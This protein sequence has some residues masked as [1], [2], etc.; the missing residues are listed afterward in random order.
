MNWQHRLAAFFNVHDDE[1]ELVSLSVA[2]YFFLGIPYVLVDTSAYALFLDAFGSQ[3]LP[4][5]YL[6]IAVGVSLLA[7]LYL[8]LADRVPIQR[9]LVL[10]MDA[11]IGITALL[12]LAVSVSAASWIAFI[13]PAWSFALINLGNII[14]WSIAGRLFDI[15]QGKRLFG[16]IGAGRWLAASAIGFLIAPLVSLLGIKN[17]LLVA[18]LSL[19]VSLLILRRL[20]NTEPFQRSLAPTVTPTRRRSAAQPAPSPNLLKNRYALMILGLTTVWVMAYFI[21]MNIYYN[22]AAVQFPDAAQLASFF[23]LISAVIGIGATIST[24]FLTGNIINRFGLRVSLFTTAALHLVIMFTFVV[25]GIAGG[26]PVILFGLAVASK[27]VDGTLNLTLD[28]AS[29]RILYQPLPTADRERAQAIA[30]GIIE[31]VGIGVGGLVLLF[32]TNV[33]NFGV[34]QQAILLL[35]V[36]VCWL[37]IASRLLRAYPLA[38][39]RA[40]T[41]RRLGETQVNLID[42]SSLS[43]LRTG[44]S[45][46]HPDAVIYS[47]GLLEQMGAASLP[48]ILPT[49]LDH[50]HPDVRLAAL[51]AIQR[52]KATSAL[53]AIAQRLDQEPDVMV[54]GTALQTL[55]SLGHQLPAGQITAYLHDPQ[56]PIRRGVLIGLSR[57]GSPDN[58][59]LASDYLTN[60]AASPHAADRVLVA[61]ILGDL[62]NAQSHEPL[63]KLLQDT[64]KDVRHAALQAAGKVKNSALFPVIIDAVED[65]QTQTAAI[66]S[67]VA[68]GE[69]VIPAL[70]DA[71]NQPSITLAKQLSQIRVC[72]RL[73]GHAVISLLLDQLAVVP[74][75][76]RSALLSALSACGYHAAAPDPIYERIKAET[77]HAAYWNAALLDLANLEQ[78]NLL[79]T[80]LNNQ[81][82]QSRDRILLWLSFI[83]DPHAIARVR[84][85]FRFGTFNQRA[86]A[87]EVIDSLL[88]Q[89]MKR[90]VLPLITDLDPA[91]RYDQLNDLFPQPHLDFSLRLHDLFQPDV[92]SW[93][94]VCILYVVGLRRLADCRDLIA[95]AQADPSPLLLELANW[96]LT[97]LTPDTADDPT[98]LTTIDKVFILQSIDIFA[99]TPA[100]ILAEVAGLLEEVSFA[101]DH[102]IFNEGDHGDS[103]YLI[104]SGQVRIFDSGTTLND[105]GPREVFG[106][107]AI[108]DPRPR[109]ATA[110]TLAPTVLLRLS[111]PA[112]SALIDER[113]EVAIGIIRVLVRRLRSRVN[114]LSHL[115]DQLERTTGM[116]NVAKN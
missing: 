87:Q 40:I 47:L 13:L 92:T 109:M 103:M 53:P 68:A 18:V 6:G 84:D 21:S 116:F 102:V 31:P 16:L 41:R 110:R 30:E 57:S 100:D 10:N 34:I 70:R 7:F 81:L 14:M 28:S 36:V 29:F 93:L 56:L 69:A 22:R 17:L 43:V 113:S 20:L 59:L 112:F 25:V 45:S 61:A 115:R 60:M 89:H 8:K 76:G 4:F 64:D 55:L 23:G 106:E 90:Y 37:W 19:C 108:L 79:I 9:L 51:Y 83:H 1:I 3:G 38:L 26:A 97:R 33:L 96:C 104:V 86:Y 42:G 65:R 39:D 82:I 46:P 63:L 101:T 88:P 48:E 54:R 35:M 85:A 32:L 11:L 95:T 44:L 75:E 49:L 94:K 98:L 99:E 77:Q 73:S 67:L 5:T 78:S 66:L 71:F 2:L 24:L 91:Q 50:A 27:L 12:W 107:M 114:D 72:S 74:L 111:A 15:R 105:L 62:G 58:A 52:L 80:A